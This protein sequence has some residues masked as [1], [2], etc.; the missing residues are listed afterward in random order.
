[1]Q[2][3]IDEPKE[4]ELCRVCGEQADY[5]CNICDEPVCDGC[6]ASGDG[7][8]YIVEETMCLECFDS[9]YNTSRASN[10]RYE[11]MQYKKKLRKIQGNVDVNLLDVED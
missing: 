5:Y 11:I 4:G 6:C 9:Q 3:D 7:I 10:R 8:H 1:M 2:K